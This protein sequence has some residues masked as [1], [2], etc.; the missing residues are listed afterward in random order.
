[1]V[2]VRELTEAFQAGVFPDTDST[3][4]D[5]QHNYSKLLDKAEKLADVRKNYTLY[6]YNN[7][8]MLSKNDGTIIGML[9]L[10]NTSILDTAYLEV[11]GIYVPP[12]FRKGPALYWLLYAV[13]E[14]VD[15]DVIADGAIF[16][17]GQE[18]IDAIIKHNM[19]N[20]FDL[21]TETGE[22][23]DVKKPITSIDHCY[24]FKTTKL[25]FG[26]QMFTE[27]MEFTWYPL[28]GEIEEIT[29]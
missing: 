14:V 22:V 24:L 16:K 3:A 8:Y 2:N 10:D 26:T 19:F 9:R 15:K 6:R 27:G 20:V 7:I 25:G 23:T 1:M 5:F 4:N 18:L 28:F 12:Q 11:K 21:N 29:I 13:K 17:D